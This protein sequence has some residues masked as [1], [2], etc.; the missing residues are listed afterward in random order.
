MPTD[1]ILYATR[2]YLGIDPTVIVTLI[3][4]KKGASGRTIVRVKAPGRDPF[5]GIHWT[6]ERPDSDNFLPVAKFLK[7]TKLN[8]PEIFY[9]IAHRRV[10]LVE[11]L[12]DTDLL[13]LKGRPFAEREPYYRSALEQ[14][15]K[16]FYSKGPKDFE[17]MPAF[18]ESLYRW[19][20]EYF[21]DHLVE[22]L[23][24]MDA[25]E[26][27]ENEVFTDLAKRLGSSAKH[28]VH[29]DF[30]SQNLLIKDDKAW[31]ID[32][33]GMR[34][35]RQEYDIA[36]LVFDPYMDHSAEDRE[37]I[38]AIWEDISEDRPETTI[39]HQCAAQRLMQA[40][41]AYGNIIKNRGDDWYAPHVPVA[42][43]MLQEVIAG[44]AL[45]KPL[46]AVLAKAAEF[47][48]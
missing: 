19:E 15:D 23:L 27:R 46:A 45:E 6:D 41:G 42:A 12:G 26:L 36:S 25:S 31:W 14:I 22:D 48:P 5:I 17:L 21:F 44:T 3:P 10:A 20:Q 11:D 47:A 43:R 40:M 18:D 30:Q 28:L 39:F 1:S 34:R 32:F 13:S 29:R 9:E 2:Q 37:A 7:A 8:V 16:L 35:G 33:Q 38:L 24:G 4:I